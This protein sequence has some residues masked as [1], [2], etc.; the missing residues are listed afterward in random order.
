MSYSKENE[1]L[2]LFNNHWSFS[3]STLGTKRGDFAARKIRPSKIRR[4]RLSKVS[5]NSFFLPSPKRSRIGSCFHRAQRWVWSSNVFSSIYI[6]Y[7]PETTAETFVGLSVK[8]FIVLSAL[9]ATEEL[10]IKYHSIFFFIFSFIWRNCVA[11]KNFV[12][13]F[14]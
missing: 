6:Y 12:W 9:S 2:C 1:K 3:R 13:V 4:F 14:R 5:A 8:V 7:S 11:S 10:F